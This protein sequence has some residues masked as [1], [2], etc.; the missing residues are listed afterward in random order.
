MIQHQ[1]QWVTAAPLWSSASKG[2]D[3]SSM[4][5]PTLLR[6]TSDTFM[7]D[8][9]TILR[10]EP[11][12]LV[13]RIATASS[14]RDRPA[15]A[16]SGWQAPTDVLKLYQP[17]HGHFNLVA[18]S[19]VCRLVGLPD[20]VVIPSRR[21][22]VGFV[23]RRLDEHGSEMG[24]VVD[25]ANPLGKTWK[26]LGA[27]GALSLDP[28]EDLIPLFPTNYTES[29]RLRRL[30]LGLIPTSSLETFQATQ[31]MSPLLPSSDDPGLK[32]ELDPRLD[33]LQNRITL[34]LSALMAPP[35]QVFGPPPTDP[36]VRAAQE[37]AEV[38]ASRF[39]VLDL[40]DFLVTN[41]QPS[42]LVSPGAPAPLPGDPEFALY[43]LFGATLVDTSGPI[44][45]RQ[46]LRTSLAEFDRLSGDNPAL[47]S[48]T[49][50]LKR[51]NLDPTILHDAV[52]AALDA[53]PP[54]PSP[55]GSPLLPS[56]TPLP[57][58]S[59]GDGTRYVLRCVFRRPDCGVFQP[60]L[61][62]EP[63]E[64]FALATFFDP[65][66][67]ARSIRIAMPIDTSIAGLRKFKKNVSFL[68]SD[69]L[70]SQ[71]GVS[72]DLKKLMDGD[73]QGGAGFSLGV[74]CSFSIPIITICAM[75]ILMIFVILLNIAFWWLPFLRICFPIRL[76]AK[77]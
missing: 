16:P 44:S 14:Y 4:R 50:D 21:E 47:P 48:L 64:P 60:D 74:I 76:K 20:R 8:L 52:K 51:T 75:I 43:Q 72:T 63:S 57:K 31:G 71:M 30:H 59:P 70:R 39:L 40:A 45:W 2:P 58:F 6:F 23:C 28:A 11:R 3:T 62:S 38:D 55:S 15:G 53:S 66:A 1:E 42:W 65:D 35:T 34:R 12:G 46:A 37:S 7:N 32:N 5:R 24:W 41:L 33:E 77:G 18:A 27:T 26:L 69:K 22:Q 13:D 54:P 67:P 73:V 36:A 61:V 25:P 29:N 17:A 56:R 9:N 19:L 68:I 49:F 10:T